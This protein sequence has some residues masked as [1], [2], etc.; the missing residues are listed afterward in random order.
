MEI[1]KHRNLALG[2]GAFLISL[3]ISYELNTLI[4][5][6]ILAVFTVLAF[7]L[8][9]LYII[10]RKRT[11][12]DK[13]IRYFPLLFFVALAMLISIFSFGKNE[14]AVLLIDNGEHEIVA[15]VKD[16]E[17]EKSYQSRYIIDVKSVDDQGLNFKALLEL[18]GE[19]LDV[20]DEVSF[21]VYFSLPEDSDI[22]YN[23]ARAYL[24]DGI[25]ILATASSYTL[26]SKGNGISA[27]EKLNLKLSSIFEEN[28][29][30]DSGALFSAILLGN[31]NL[32]DNSIKRD[33][34]RVGVSHALALSGMH[35][36]V[37]AT[38]LG[39][40]FKFL[41]LNLHFKNFILILCIIF[42]VALT[43]FSESAIRAGLMMSLY[44]LIKMVGYRVD[45]VTSLFLSVT[46]IC[47]FM[48]YSIFSISLMLSFLAMLG[49]LISVRYIYKT[50]L[51]RTRFV[52]FRW[53][54]FSLVTTLFVVA[55]TLPVTFSA[56]G[57][58]SI[59]TPVSNIILVPYF[60]LLIYFAPFLLLFSSVPYISDFLFFLGDRG[61]HW[62]LEFIRWLADA[63]GIVIPTFS[64]VQ[65]IGVY[66]I[67][68]ALVLLVLVKRKYIKHMTCLLLVGA[69]V[70]ASGSIINY[71]Q[72]KN[73]VY[74]SSYSS[75]SNDFI[76]IEENNNLTVIDISKTTTGVAG[77]SVGLID[78]LHYSEVENYIICD[79]SHLTDLYFK[80]IAGNIKIETLYIP[81]PSDAKEMDIYQG[82]IRVAKKEKI[83][84]AELQHNMKLDIATIEFSGN[85]TLPRSER[86]NVSFNISTN[87][88]DF[89]YLG[90]S[91]YEIFDYFTEEKS[92]NADVIVF[93]S[94]GPI[95]KKQ[96]SYITP[97]V[98]KLIFYG[99]SYIYADSEMLKDEDKIILE[100]K[101]PVRFKAE[102]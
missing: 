53:I 67:V 46:I 13:I 54:I 88:C 87:D 91:S 51:K 71:I 61:A 68:F 57:T 94:Y 64:I 40:I 86:K 50:R 80:R 41:P 33:C 75:R 56:F 82:I 17:Y 7:L 20:D 92:Y 42:F 4:R 5:M 69:C 25:S 30:E 66:L 89:L 15:T 16:E 37:I 81:R 43:G 10:K 59:L 49:C 52:V 95:Y 78:Y 12:L 97:Y 36:T 38:L 27:L 44:Y 24:D 19:G 62:L 72:A 6:I 32:L 31:D 98:D 93:G 76:T 21:Y 100:A 48:P 90:A 35:I 2:C 34:A 22:G 3:F 26:I 99:E 63:R 9:I 74:I 23:E 58:L 83:K 29:S 96:Y 102:K 84:V 18:E 55:F 11:I 1:F 60:T 70:F 79:Y 39:I 101:K 85:N 28:M 77:T 73:N 65:I 14:K 45:N 8:A 47:I